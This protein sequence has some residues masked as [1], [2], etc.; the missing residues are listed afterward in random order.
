MKQIYL[1][2]FFNLF[3][4][5]CVTT[6]KYNQ[7]ID[8]EISVNEL[9]KDIDFVEKKI[10]K[11][12]PSADWYITEQQLSYKFDSI[13]SL[14]KKP[15]TPNEFYLLISYPVTEVKQAHMS[16]QPLLKKLSKS[17]SKKLKNKGMGPLSQLKLIWF[18]QELFVKQNLSPDTT[19]INGTKIIA[20]DGITPLEIYN[21]YKKTL[22][23]DGYNQTW[24]PKKFNR[25]LPT[26]FTLEKGIKDSISYQMSFKDSIF[27]KTLVRIENK[28]APKTNENSTS[29]TLKVETVKHIY[30]KYANKRRK[31]S[32]KTVS[33]NRRVFGYDYDL[34]CYAKDLKILEENPKVAVLKVTSFSKGQ[35]KRA[36]KI[37]FDSIKKAGIETLILDLRDNTGGL[38]EDSRL[39]FGY[40]SKK[41]Y[42][43]IQKSKVTSRTSIPTT[44]YRNMSKLG[45]AI[46]TPFKPIASSIL[47][48][49]TSKDNEGNYYFKIRSENLKNPEELA[50]QGELYVL[51]NG[52]SFSASCLLA[53]NL[54][55][56][57]R[58][59]FVGEE[60]GG[61][62]NGTVAGFMPIFKLPNS[63]LRLRIGLMDIR[64]VYQ[65]IIEGKG[66]QPDYYIVPTLED[67]IDD[68]D[69]QLNWVIE[70]IK[71]KS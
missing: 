34:K 46:L 19:I 47:Y 12:H 52:G 53:A 55:G 24:L 3:L 26:F 23:S 40:L 42:K 4:S 63:K 30:D 54:K 21:K 57:E 27:I 8:Q 25:S 1:I 17:E 44:A 71:M 31:D 67:I 68:R 59:F 2:L 22:A 5:S 28:N 60:T 9:L 6:K 56:S 35:Y 58:G 36:Y 50:F 38:I 41:S 62:F 39:L 49:K 51:I 48:A 66:V 10:K 45:S 61:T 43:F 29:D 18:N 11:L 15:L 65:D 13:R 32:L 69:V 7:H 37:I 70:Q 16:V 20:F 14:I 33:K 64:P